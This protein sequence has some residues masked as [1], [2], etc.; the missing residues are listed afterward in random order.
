MCIFFGNYT[1]NIFKQSGNSD[2][3][4]GSTPGNTY[5]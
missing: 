1:K 4:G 5:I 3:D 2:D